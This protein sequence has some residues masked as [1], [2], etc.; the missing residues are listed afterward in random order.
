M[1]VLLKLEQDDLL[2]RV[3]VI[4]RRNHVYDASAARLD[5]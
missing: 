4:S 2:E 1:D 5:R 3:E